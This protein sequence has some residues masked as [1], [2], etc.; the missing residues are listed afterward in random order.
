[1]QGPS[2]D[3]DFAVAVRELCGIAV[4]ICGVLVARAAHRQRRRRREDSRAA[5]A[6]M[7]RAGMLAPTDG[8]TSDTAPARRVHRARGAGDVRHAGRSRTHEGS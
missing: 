7:Q 4:A 6:V 5:R 3:T 2:G 1:V 8:R